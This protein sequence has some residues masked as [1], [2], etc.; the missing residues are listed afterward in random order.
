MKQ[1]LIQKKIEKE[2]IFIPLP[3]RIIKQ[4][5]LI[6][7]YYHPDHLGSTTLITNASGSIVEETFYLPFGD[8]LE[9]GDESRYN[10]NSKEKDGTELNYYG[11][12]YYKSTQGQFIQAD[13]LIQNVYN[14]Q[15]LNRYSYV[16]NNPY[17]YV[18]P[19]GNFNVN[20][21]YIKNFGAELWRQLFY[22]GSGGFF[23]QSGAFVGEV[24]LSSLNTEL[25]SLAN[26]AFDK[27][28]DITK[29][30]SGRDPKIKSNFLKTEAQKPD[31]LK[32]YGPEGVK[33]MKEGKNPPGFQV[34]HKEPL[35][36]GGKDVSSN[37]ELK[38]KGPG[39]TQH[40]G[41]HYRGGETY[42]K[43]GPPQR[44]K[45]IKIREGFI[46]KLK[47]IFEK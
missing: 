12:R 19:T 13:S 33:N 16:L 22:V 5:E 36:T 26:S 3:P 30:K 29:I 6:K 44:T 1:Q 9:G 14:P 18:D 21:D 34:H 31:A 23:M 25:G 47:K 8:V 2:I 41:T 24:K 37:L 42:E 45:E 35:Y 7:K 40:P 15:G 17:R 32:K 11:A 46:S 43:Y 20:I 4:I 28:D 39:P 27:I 10:Y 38:S